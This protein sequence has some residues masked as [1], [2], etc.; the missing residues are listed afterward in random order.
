MQQKNFKYDPVSLTGTSFY[1]YGNMFFSE[2]VLSYLQNVRSYNMIQGFYWFSM[3]NQQWQKIDP[4]CKKE[5]EYFWKLSPLVIQI[6]S[7]YF[8]TRTFIRGNPV[9]TTSSIS[10]NTPSTL[11]NVYDKADW[12]LVYLLSIIC[13]Y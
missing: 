7:H 5:S 8:S 6:K 12:I 13:Y 10:I 4:A 2:S 11:G 9:F 3:F 1:F